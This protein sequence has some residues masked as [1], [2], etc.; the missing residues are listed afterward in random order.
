MEKM[1]EQR[2]RGAFMKVGSTDPYSEVER[3]LACARTLPK[4]EGR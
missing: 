3:W 1:V 4:T 2:G